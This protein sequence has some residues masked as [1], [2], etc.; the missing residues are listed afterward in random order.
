MTDPSTAEIF[1]TLD[2]L[3]AAQAAHDLQGMLEAYATDGF[4]GIEDMRRYFEGLIERDALRG[5]TVDM[6]QCETF[7]YRDNALI[8][9]VIY[10][11]RKGPRGFSFHLRRDQAGKWR[12]IDN[13]RSQLPGEQIYTAQLLADAGRVVGSRGMVWTRRFDVPVSDV[14]RAI[15][16]KEGL[17]QWWL[18]HDVEIDLKPGGI[19]KHHWTNTIGDFQDKRF[20]D[21]VGSPDDLSP[22]ANLM[23]FKLEADGPGTVFSLFDGFQAH[24]QPLSLPWT[25]SGWHGTVNALETH[26]TGRPSAHDFGLGGD[27]YW[28]YLRAHH[29]FADAVGKLDPTQISDEDWRSAYTKPRL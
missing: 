21:F 16:T 22:G 14:W 25:A 2:R 17:D 6:T 28:S 19:F 13:N 24:L 8:K 27:F 4:V 9:P 11:T 3:H 5:R 20:I 15:S 10:H 12:V 7:V 1:E 29:A 23:R 18:I 26:L